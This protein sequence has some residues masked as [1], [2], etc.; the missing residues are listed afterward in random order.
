MTP[1]DYA[2]YV[3]W[4]HQELSLTAFF[5]TYKN[6]NVQMTE[7]MQA[8]SEATGGCITVLFSACDPNA[9]SKVQTCRYVFFFLSV[10]VMLTPVK[11]SSGKRLRGQ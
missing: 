5:S 11:F 4:S 6:A 9:G 8:L 2:A 10:E 3:Y 7:F 1:E